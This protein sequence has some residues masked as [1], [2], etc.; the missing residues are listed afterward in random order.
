LRQ[1]I[2]H[3]TGPLFRRFNSGHGVYTRGIG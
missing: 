1:F 3:I 2:H